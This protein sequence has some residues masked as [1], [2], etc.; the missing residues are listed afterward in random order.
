[1][2]ELWSCPVL[3]YYPYLY[4][5][6]GS[7]RELCQGGTAPRSFPPEKWPTI[8]P[9]GPVLDAARD[10]GPRGNYHPG[11]ETLQGWV[12]QILVRDLESLG[13]GPA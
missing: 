9:W 13:I 3:E 11:P 5:N 10:V 2:R 6:A 12:D 1:V 7:G 4:K 8:R